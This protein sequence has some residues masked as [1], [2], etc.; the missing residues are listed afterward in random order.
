MHPGHKMAEKDVS[1]VK[2]FNYI[3]SLGGFAEITELLKLPSPLAKKDSE[4][5]VISWYESEKKAG[6]FDSVSNGVAFIQGRTWERCWYS[7]QPKEK[8]VSE[9]HLERILSN[10]E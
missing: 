1:I 6:S 5:S 4:S 3:C 2:V 9:L 7:N 10:G 8:V